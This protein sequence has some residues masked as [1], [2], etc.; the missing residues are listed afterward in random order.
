MKT[1]IL[2][3]AVGSIT[4]IGAVILVICS[5]I[6]GNPTLIDDKEQTSKMSVCNINNPISLL[7]NKVPF[8]V[9]V[10]TSLPLSLSYELASGCVT[11]F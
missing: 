9:S 1:W 8:V 3:C 5:A 6:N 7:I 2:L 4:I 10:F 11:V